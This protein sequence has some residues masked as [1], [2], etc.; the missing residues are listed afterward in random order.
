MQKFILLIQFVY[1][2]F[3]CWFSTSLDT[4]SSCLYFVN[5]FDSYTS[6]NLQNFGS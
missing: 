3:K 2:P 1:T 6:F 4:V 5:I